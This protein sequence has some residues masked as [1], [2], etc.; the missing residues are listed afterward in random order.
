MA[1]TSAI[2]AQNQAILMQIKSHMSQHA[3]SVPT[4]AAST[5]SPEEP[6]PT[7]WQALVDSFDVLA[8]TAVATTPPAAPQPV[9][10]EDDS[11]PATK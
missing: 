6:V 8:A 4:P 10:D 2:L 11:S 1:H 9:Q 7:P 3:I 5:P